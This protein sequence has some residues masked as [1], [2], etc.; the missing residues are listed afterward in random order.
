MRR[1]RPVYESPSRGWIAGHAA[2]CDLEIVHGYSEPGSSQP[3]ELDNSTIV[4][5]VVLSGLASSE[6]LSRHPSSD[7][8][9]ERD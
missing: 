4:P 6:D 7:V 3:L 9:G 8:D 1:A 5:P 2:E